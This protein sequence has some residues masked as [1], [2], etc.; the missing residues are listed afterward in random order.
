M[1][2]NEKKPE[3]GIEILGQ[4]F[5]YPQTIYGVISVACVIAGICIIVWIIAVKANPK[6]VETIAGPF[7]IGRATIEKT[8][9]AEGGYLIQF[10]TPSAKTKESKD[11][12]AWE[13]VGSDDRLNEFADRLLKDRRV[14]G[15]RRYEVIGQ[16]IGERRYGDWWVMSVNNDYSITDFVKTYQDF[17]KNEGGIYVEVLHSGGGKH[18]K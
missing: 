10:W 2:D 6:V 9:P 8:E 16:G 4:V 13:K 3:G 1:N 11:V 17:W 15:Y 14:H 18:L 7:L 12:A 5:Y